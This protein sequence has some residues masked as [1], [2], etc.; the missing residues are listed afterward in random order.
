MDGEHLQPETTTG[1]AGAAGDP[2]MSDV[3]ASASEP[4]AAP[5][6]EPPALCGKTYAQ[7]A[8]YSACEKEPGHPGN[9]GPGGE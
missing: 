4:K 5:V 1:E 9:C 2:A 3:A 7:G 8:A 6:P